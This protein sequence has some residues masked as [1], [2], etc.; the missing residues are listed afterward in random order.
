[1]NYPPSHSLSITVLY[2][3]SSPPPSVNS[4]LHC[5]ELLHYLTA[6]LF[7]NDPRVARQ[8]LQPLFQWV[9]ESKSVK[10]SLTDVCSQ[11]FCHFL[12][13][14]L[15]QERQKGICQVSDAGKT[16]RRKPPRIT[17]SQKTHTHTHTNTQKHTPSNKNHL[18]FKKAEQKP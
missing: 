15:A 13:L 9:C 14:S 1:M 11:S 17:Q 12:S 18:E 7:L 6:T 3:T 10:T 4:L 5:K 8:W 2:S 16:Q